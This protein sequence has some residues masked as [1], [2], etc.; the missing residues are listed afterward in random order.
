MNIKIGDMVACVISRLVEG[1]YKSFV[2]P[3]VIVGKPECFFNVSE[4][5][6]IIWFDDSSEFLYDEYDVTN[7]REIY[8]KVQE[9]KYG[10]KV[11]TW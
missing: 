3:G 8:V 4:S 5:W 9:G 7:F 10:Q 11:L 6:S 1:E 2:I